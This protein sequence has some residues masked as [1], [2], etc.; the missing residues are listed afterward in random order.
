MIRVFFVWVGVRNTNS[1][2]IMVWDLL[3]NIKIERTFSAS[4]RDKTHIGV[5]NT[6]TDVSSDVNVFVLIGAVCT[7]RVRVSEKTVVTD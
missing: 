6:S 5:R 3:S 7:R 4:S 1:G 2:M